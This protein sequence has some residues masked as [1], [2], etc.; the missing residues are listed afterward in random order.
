MKTI[1]LKS[2]VVTAGELERKF[3]II[4]QFISSFLT[5][6]ENQ[7]MNKYLQH[8]ELKHCLILDKDLLEQCITL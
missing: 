6:I 8:L 4:N 7:D 1:L 3:H 2:V 5:S